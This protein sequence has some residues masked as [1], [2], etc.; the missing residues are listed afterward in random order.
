[1]AVFLR[2][3]VNFF[4][5][6]I[7]D[8][9]TFSFSDSVATF[10]GSALASSY[11][12]LIANNAYMKPLDPLTVLTALSRMTSQDMALG[13]ATIVAKPLTKATLSAFAGIIQGLGDDLK[14]MG[15]GDNGAREDVCSSDSE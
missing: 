4:K 8:A 13:A 15:F 1:M 5:S 11:V 14:R 12:R 10:G 6:Y 2:P 7:N 3:P 9:R